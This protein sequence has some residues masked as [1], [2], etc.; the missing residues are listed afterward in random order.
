MLV[1]WTNS[2]A[3]S[4]GEEKADLKY[5]LKEEQIGHEGEWKV[6]D[7]GKEENKDE[8]LTW[9]KRWM[10]EPFNQMEKNWHKP[11]CLKGGEW[12]GAKG[13]SSVLDVLTFW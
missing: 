8:P 13:K 12:W 10:A 11:V 5:I 2:G 4:T 6:R 9:A 7:E 1:A 3:S